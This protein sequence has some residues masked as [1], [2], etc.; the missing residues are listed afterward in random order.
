LEGTWRGY[1]SNMDRVVHREVVPGERRKYLA[2]LQKTFC[3][4]YTDGTTLEL[5]VREALPRER[6]EE[7][8]SYGEL[9]RGISP[10]IQSQG[11]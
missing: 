7:K 11:A 5:H 8:H 9:I 1:S 6:V 3:I 4:L 10:Q 2:W